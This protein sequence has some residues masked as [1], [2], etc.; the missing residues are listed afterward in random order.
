MADPVVN[1]AS[2]TTGSA[3]NSP[4]GIQDG[5]LHRQIE[6]THSGTWRLTPSPHHYAVVQ[7]KPEKWIVQ[8]GLDDK[9]TLE[10]ARA[11]RTKK[12]LVYLVWVS[13]P[14]SCW[15]HRSG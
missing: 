12:Y 13:Q 2:T 6:P 8:L 9:I 14:F 15:Q 3:V 4:A 10:E 11:M 1:L 5:L 7:L